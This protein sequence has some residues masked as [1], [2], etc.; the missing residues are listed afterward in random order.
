MSATHGR[1]FKNWWLLFVKGIIIALFGVVFLFK[2]FNFKILI[3]AFIVITI[4]NGLLILYGTLHY[5]KSNVH[6]FYWLIEGTFDFVLGII[7]IV[8][9]IMME[10]LSYLVVNLLLIQ[11]IAL[12][13]L[14]HGI[15]H[16]LSANKVKKYVPSARI[17]LFSGLGV[18]IL[19]LSIIAL[20]IVA[21]LK[22]L[23]FSLPDFYFIGGFCILIG[24]LLSTISVVLRKIYSE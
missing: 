9:I 20:A 16:S 6:W 8:A 7:G 5:R 22:P 21:L 10:M 19:S 14:I 1:L 12:W 17:A 13:A 15:I 2:L 4:I 11:I 24:L 18:I 23:L 3:Q